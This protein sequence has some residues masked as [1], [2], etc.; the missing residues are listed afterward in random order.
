MC[1]CVSRTSVEIEPDLR[2]FFAFG[3]VVMRAA[4]DSVVRLVL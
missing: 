4:F 3:G 2:V 1:V